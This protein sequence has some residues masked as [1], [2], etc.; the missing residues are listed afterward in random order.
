MEYSK[1][2]ENIKIRVKI[3]RKKQDNGNEEVII[4]FENL[5]DFEVNLSKN[6]TDDLK[7]FFDKIFEFIVEKK[8]LINF[9][10]CDEENDLYTEIVSDIIEQINSEIKISEESFIKIF[11]LIDNN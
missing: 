2:L 1:N 9:I 6:N 10:L 3:N 8:K 5:E 4:K 11:S 7:N